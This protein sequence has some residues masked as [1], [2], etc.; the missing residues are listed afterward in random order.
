MLVPPLVSNFKKTSSNFTECH[1]INSSDEQ[2]QHIGTKVK[3]KVGHTWPR[4][5]P[6]GRLTSLF[7]WSS[8]QPFAAMIARCLGG[9]DGGGGGGGGGNSQRF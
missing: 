5:K 6:L 2:N 4:L 8:E 7:I 3:S 9:V 1:E